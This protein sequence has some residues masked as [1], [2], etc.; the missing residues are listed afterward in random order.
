MLFRR[1]VLLVLLPLAFFAQA[2][3]QG[4]DRRFEVVW[5]TTTPQV[6]WDALGIDYKLTGGF[7]AHSSVYHAAV[8]PWNGTD[9]PQVTD[10]QYE[11][12]HFSC[13]A[14]PPEAP[15][16]E[17]T[18]SLVTERGE[19]LVQVQIPA[20][21]WENGELKC[22]KNYRIL[23]IQL[24]NQKLRG[25]RQNATT[26]DYTK[27][28]HS[29]L[30]S[31]CWWRIKVTESAVYRISYEELQALGFEHPERLSVWGGNPIQ[32]PYSNEEKHVD[33][34]QQI[35]IQWVTR[36][37]VPQSGDYALVFLN[38]SVW[39]TY[40]SSRQMF[41][42]HEHD[43]D[44][45]AHYFITTDRPTAQIPT[46]STPLPTFR[47]TSYLGLWGYR[48]A[49]NNLNGAGRE[50]FGPIY[51]FHVQQSQPTSL[52]N[53]VVGTEAKLF[54]RVAAAS[55]KP[56]AFQFSIGGT[57]VAYTEVKALIK[58]SENMAEIKEFVAPFT[59]TQ[60]NLDFDIRY[61]RPL[62]SS[63]GWISRLCLQARQHFPESLQQQVLF[64]SEHDPGAVPNTYS[65]W[66]MPAYPDQVQLWDVTDS[67]H[68]KRFFSLQTAS[69]Q[70]TQDARLVLFNPSEL[71]GVQ[72]DCEVPN[73]DLHASTIPELLI[74]APDRFFS[75][76]Q[77]LADIYR[78]SAL[79][80]H[81]HVAVV[82]AEQ[83]YNEFSSG[84]LDATAIRNYVRNIYWRSGGE[85]S[86][87]RYLLL[88]G[89]AYYKLR[90]A[91]DDHNLLPNYQ[92]AESVHR[93]DTYSTDDFFGFLDPDE[94]G[95]HGAL[96]IGI[97]RYAIAQQE[98]ADL[99][100]RHEQSYHTQANWGSW[101]TKTVMLADDQDNN[102]YMR[103]SDT[104]ALRIEKERKDILVKRIYTDAFQ[105][106]NAWNRPFYSAV[107][108]EINRQLNQGTYL[109]NYVGHASPIHFADE[110]I[111]T[112]QDVASWRN[113]RNLPILVAAS[114]LFAQSD[115]E[116]NIT[117]GQNMLFMPQGGGIAL[118]AASRLT[119][120]YSNQIFNSHLLRSILPGPKSTPLRSIGDALRISKNK[121]PGGENRSK[122]LLLGNPALPLPNFTAKA[123]LIA[124]NQ[125][126]LKG[127][128]DT[129]RA[130]EK[131]QL[132]V[133]VTR[134]DGVPF[135]G[136]VHLQLRG[137]YRQLRTKANDGGEVFEYSERTNTVFRGKA[138]CTNGRVRYSFIVP[139]DMELDYGTGSL[140]LFATSDD[141]LASGGYDEWIV[142]GRVNNTSDDR[143]GPDIEI[144][145]NDYARRPQS[146]I[147]TNAQ[148]IVRLRDSSGINISG[149]GLGH[150]LTA[151]LFGNGKQEK[152]VLNDF[153]VADRDSYKKGEVRYHF[154]NLEPGKYTLKVQ[155]YDVYNNPSEN[156][157]AFEVGEPKEAKISN[158]LNYPN[159]FTTSTSFYFDATRPGQAAEVLIQIFTPDGLLVRSLHFSE[160]SPSFRMGP[161]FW[162]GKDEWGN[163]IG[164]GVYFYRVRLRYLGNWL[165]KASNTETYER[166]LKL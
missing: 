42:Y 5:E 158:L 62:Y 17:P 18:A 146:I 41:D 112:E 19:R 88:F 8:Y 165:E 124:L 115:A 28:A 126:P 123:K 34:L 156:T 82:D 37:A 79:V 43:Y 1:Y 141:Q 122:Y 11:T 159:P 163:P 71:P 138:T 45:V 15:Y 131:V 67:F 148:L 2:L 70:A 3:G 144:F 106:D 40:N 53:S 117:L 104:M 80:R 129:I 46:V 14:Q 100:L 161:Y 9:L 103:G 7:L 39:W 135:S 30:A 76:A 160:L 32:L 120:N 154:T 127:A 147:S 162:D 139:T 56:S 29:Q 44:P 25:L 52:H 69:V 4:V 136:D 63:T 157:I 20:F 119:Y 111:F 137:P 64:Y 94:D 140:T 91:H 116:R 50:N 55:F 93:S 145:W 133:E 26:G 99:I 68:P 143:Q 89:K 60:A 125:K 97:G 149:A 166:L 12:A 102:A 155:A 38:G 35:P 66:Q 151:T 150:D 105:Q 152:I 61:I 153:Y 86:R 33:D 73:Q 107:N 118:I 142:G 31:G 90:E 51:D 92:S 130:G 21:R 110:H 36:A 85:A 113:L 24:A 27:I 134:P 128:L 83:I 16:A 49:Q 72:W 95:V 78:N 132:E 48:G 57:K 84:N 77:A 121:T 6:R 74:V 22:L 87:F 10:L 23:P 114:C 96:D 65:G 108:K 81:M 58:H 109:L 13:N 59:V 54:A 75:Q 164:R 101:L 98:Q 47:H